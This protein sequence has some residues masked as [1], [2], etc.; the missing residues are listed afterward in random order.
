MKEK[1][2][3]GCVNEVNEAVSGLMT[4]KSFIKKQ[5]GACLISDYNEALRE[6]W[7]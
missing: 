5:T 6:A 2:I 1:E 4:K 7:G 3:D